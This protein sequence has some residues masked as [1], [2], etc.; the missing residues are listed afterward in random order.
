MQAIKSVFADVLR[1]FEQSPAMQKILSGNITLEHYKSYLRQTFHYTRENPQIQAQATVY[2]RGTDRDF[3]KMFYKHSIS[4]I[5]HD[6]LAL[7]DL[8]FFIGDVNSIRTENPLPAT[9]AFNAF[10]T[11][12]ITNRN[13]IGYLGHLFFLEF[14]PTSSGNQYIQILE[15]AGIP[16]EAMSFLIEHTEVDVY[17]NKLME[18]YVQ[19]LVLTDADLHSVIYTMKGSAKLYVEMLNA[20]FAQ[21]DNPVGWGVNY[22][23]LERFDKARKQNPL[24]E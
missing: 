7:N 18:K 17:Q 2:F 19:G 14:L 23:E 24:Q 12:Q 21:V 15:N 16:K 20:A 13:P 5:G 10:A 11:Y 4:E 9:I 1:D 6:E 22:F 8:K 3:I